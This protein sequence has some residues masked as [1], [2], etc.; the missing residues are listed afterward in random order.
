M[1]VSTRS[2]VPVSTSVQS[3]TKG[4]ILTQRTDFKSPRTIEYYESNL[5]RFLWYAYEWI[6]RKWRGF[7]KEM[8]KLGVSITA[9]EH[10]LI[11]GLTN[12]KQ[13]L[14][15]MNWRQLASDSQLDCSI[16]SLSGSTK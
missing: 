6:Y 8:F 7:S 1:V 15:Y 4:F 14:D 10:E 16:A 5:R 12:L 11:H 13:R 2:Q 9:H 3:L